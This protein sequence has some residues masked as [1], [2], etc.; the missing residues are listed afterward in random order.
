MR[1]ELTWLV[2]TE[3]PQ[4]TSGTIMLPAAD[5]PVRARNPISRQA[6]VQFDATP[7]NEDPEFPDTDR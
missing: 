4:V 7:F 3:R 6:H 5:A 2:K 1:D